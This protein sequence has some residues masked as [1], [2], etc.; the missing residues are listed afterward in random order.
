MLII[1]TFRNLTKILSNYNTICKE[2]ILQFCIP[3]SSTGLDFNNDQ[4]SSTM[5]PDLI[6]QHSSED[7]INNSNSSV[8]KRT[9][10]ADHQTGSNHNIV[11]GSNPS[12]SNNHSLLCRTRSEDAA[13]SSNE[14]SE[15]GLTRSLPRI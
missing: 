3:L 15:A 8:L 10:S 14:V 7:S 5:N 12:E 1:W 13:S 2:N 4:I 11:T 9:S 6:H